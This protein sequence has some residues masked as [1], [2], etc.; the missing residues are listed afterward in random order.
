MPDAGN[1]TCLSVFGVGGARPCCRRASGQLCLSTGLGVCGSV[2][3]ERVCP[4][5]N[6]QPASLPPF[7][8]QITDW[9]VKP[10]GSVQLATK[11]TAP[12]RQRVSQKPHSCP[13]V[14]KT[15]RLRRPPP[16]PLLQLFPGNCE[17]QAHGPH[18]TG[19][20][21]EGQGP[22]PRP[23]GHPRR[24]RPGLGHLDGDR[25]S[26]RCRRANK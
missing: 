18:P 1:A 20:R 16:G 8:S 9:R 6:T 2:A 17:E 21:D 26:A 11:D 23:H 5:S 10:L 4:N 14:S 7:R 12:Q 13:T 22:L 24:A 3:P 15:R 25:D 19:H